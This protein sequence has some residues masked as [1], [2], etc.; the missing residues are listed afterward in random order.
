MKSQSSLITLF[1]F[2]IGIVAMACHKSNDLPPYTGPLPIDYTV[3]P[4]A[5]QEGKNTIG[6]KINGKVWVPRVPFGAVTYTDITLFVGEQNNYGAGNCVFNLVDIDEGIEDWFAILFGPNYFKP[7]EYHCTPP[8]Y[9]E[10]YCVAK[11]SRLG[12]Y[13]DL[14]YSIDNNS[15]QFVITKIDTVQNFISGTFK[16][17]FYNVDNKNDSLK[18]TDGRFDLKY[19]PQ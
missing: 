14:D 2:L 6:C 16:F 9:V 19:Y 18:I 7:I 5:T 8:P 10:N 12:Q 13:Y 3:L 15:N 4:P 11:L 1:A 17:T